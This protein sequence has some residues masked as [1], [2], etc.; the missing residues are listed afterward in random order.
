MKKLNY[1]LAMLALCV[2]WG[3]SED[4]TT[5]LAV[6]QDTLTFPYQGGTQS[7]SI[8]SDGQW[9]ISQLPEW[10]SASIVSGNGNSVVSFTATE[11]SAYDDREGQVVVYATDGNYKQMLTIR[12]RGTHTSEITVNSKEEIVFGGRSSVHYDFDALEAL[13]D[14]V[15]VTC[16]TEWEIEIPSWMAVA[17]SGKIVER[18]EKTLF[19]GSGDLYMMM[20]ETYNGDDARQGTVIMRTSSG[21]SQ[22]NIPVRQLG[23]DE[24]FGYNFL[25]TPTGYVCNYEIGANVEKIVTFLTSDMVESS[26]LTYQD[27]NGGLLLNCQEYEYMPQQVLTGNIPSDTELTLFAI[28]VDA[29]NYYAPLSRVY[30]YKYHS[31]NESELLPRVEIKDV[32]YEDGEWTWTVKPN[33][34]TA[35][36][37]TTILAKA[38]IMST[39][40]S[41]EYWANYFSWTYQNVPGYY[42]TSD[43]EKTFTIKANSKNE[44]IIIFAIPHGITGTPSVVEFYVSDLFSQ[45]S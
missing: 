34:Y 29:N 21:E 5:S 8:T 13:K 4:D 30:S 22:V 36:Y 39:G 14:Y 20:N 38:P 11:N 25:K 37:A 19:S 23:K 32:K 7:L 15:A 35:I 31:L 28:G 42:K 16:D 2:L 43:S 26:S 10:V 33:E 6:V 45:N 12:Q 41:L 1:L 44:D 17:F 27:F 18:G 40:L 9:G 24:V 3:C